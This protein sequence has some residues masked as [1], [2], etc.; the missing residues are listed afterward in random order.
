METP[1]NENPADSPRRENAVEGE[2][3][4]EEEEEEESEANSADL[5]DELQDFR[6]RWQRELR[7]AGQ[8]SSF[9]DA[10]EDGQT[11]EDQA[12]RLFMQ[13]MQAEQNGDLYGNYGAIAFYRRAMQLV[14]D[15]ESKIDFFQH[16]SPRPRQDSESSADG[17][18]EI[19]EDLVQHFQHINLDDNRVCHPEYEQRAAHISVLPMEVLMYIFR[20]V[21]SSQLDMRSLEMLGQVCRGFYLCARDEG[22]WKA[23]CVRVWGK[24]CG[25]SKK[26]GSW[27]R[28][29]LDRPH[30]LFNG[31]YISRATYVRQGEQS[32][33]CFYRPF[34]MVEY[35]RFLRF[36]PEGSVLMM[37]SSDDPTVIVPKLRSAHTA[38]QGL[39]KGY[40]KLSG[41]K[42]MCVVKR[43]K[44]PELVMRYKRQRQANN[45]ND[46]DQTYTMEFELSDNGRKCHRRLN[47]VS[48]S[49]RTVYKVSGDETVADFE[50]KDA[51]YPPLIFSRVRSFTAAA[52]TP[53]Q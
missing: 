20:W 25:S 38:L 51:A 13:G 23:A 42:V 35:Y 26:Y 9:M 22:L 7:D 19:E 48:Y 46:L 27:R 33:D 30:L 53:L 3:E 8:L 21:V 44:S 6:Q 2:E 16:R 11:D 36:F 45:Q 41:A 4:E 50:L 12:K 10:R 52:E 40:Y 28:M 31:C 43:V 18:V 49:V 39:M 17:S 24:N 14:P 47:W 32:L 1:P 37:C 5:Q 29:F 34:H 15:I